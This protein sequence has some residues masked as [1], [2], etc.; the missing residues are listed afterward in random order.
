[1]LLLKQLGSNKIFFKKEQQTDA[2]AIIS[3]IFLLQFYCYIFFP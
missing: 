2:I 1:M 3:D